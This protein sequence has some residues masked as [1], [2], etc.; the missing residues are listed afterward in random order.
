[1]EQALAAVAEKAKIV[2]DDI[3]KQIVPNPD[4]VTRE[5]FAFKR[6]LR[7][8]FADVM[9]EFEK[10]TVMASVKKKKAKEVA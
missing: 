2:E 10:H 6:G 1:M 8:A 9:G 5:S 7:T 4:T 3:E